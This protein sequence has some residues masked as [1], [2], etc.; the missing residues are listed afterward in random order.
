MVDTHVNIFKKITCAYPVSEAPGLVYGLV[1]FIP[2]FIMTPIFV[3]LVRI[4]FR[5]QLNMLI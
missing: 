4:L 2:K 3:E 1:K 5:G